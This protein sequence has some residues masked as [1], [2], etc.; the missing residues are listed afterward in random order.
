[1]AKA[2]AS[3]VSTPSATAQLGAF[4]LAP[5]YYQ[6]SVIAVDSNNNTSP[7]AQAFVTLV[8]T[9]L[10]GIRVHPNPW[11]PNQT[12]GRQITFDQL[13]LGATVKIFTVSGHW[14][15][16]PPTSGTTAIWDLT[17]DSGDLVASGL[18]IYLVKTSDGQTTKG[19]LA[20]IK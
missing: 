16:T 14:V 20:I 9:S 7:P 5:G 19:K 8:S 13:P 1:M 3:T 6:I 17:N 2:V 12:Y 15:K 11:R 18:Y 10:S 4:N